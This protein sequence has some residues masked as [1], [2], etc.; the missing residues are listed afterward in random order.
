MSKDTLGF[1]Q[2]EEGGTIKTSFTLPKGTT[3]KIGN[4][5]L[6][7]A[8][9]TEFCR[10]G[11]ASRDEVVGNLM[12][13]GVTSEGN[14]GYTTQREVEGK[15]VAVDVTYDG[16]G[17]P[18]YKLAGEKTMPT[19]TEI[20][21]AVEG[22]PTGGGVAASNIAT[23]VSAGAGNIDI[24]LAEIEKLDNPLESRKSDMQLQNE[25]GG[26]A[27]GS[28][29]ASKAQTETKPKSGSTP[30]KV[31]AETNSGTSTQSVTETKTKTGK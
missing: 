15:K 21:T 30:A 17:A 27:K 7:L 9:D 12:H 1:E 16:S 4:D 10:D 13:A 19:T 6:T 28:K 29:S 3:V 22:E 23:G 20:G 31:S 8:N 2:K 14:Y 24:P 25:Y 26:G 11:A 18:L 5:T